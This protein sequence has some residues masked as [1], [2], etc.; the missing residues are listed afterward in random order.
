MK[1]LPWLFL[2]FAVLFPIVLWGAL[3]AWSQLRRKSGPPVGEK[4]EQPLEEP[5]T[6]TRKA[7]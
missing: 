7:G 3:E 2:Y 6:I 4:P 5:L 1:T